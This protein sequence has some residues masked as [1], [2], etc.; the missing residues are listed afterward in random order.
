MNPL[1]WHNCYDQSWKGTL[2]DDAFAHPAKFA[3]ALVERILRHG[4][5]QGYWRVGET[6]GDPFGG[7]ACGGIVAGMLGL[8]WVGVELEPRFVELG[9]KNIAANR[10]FFAG[11]SVEL[12]QGDSR[13]FAEI[14]CGVAGTVCSPPFGDQ[15]PSNNNFV[16]PNDS[17]KRMATDVSTGY[18]NTPGQI[19]ALPAGVV[20]SPPYAAISPEKSSGSIDLRKNYETY[21]ASGGGA[22][23][24]AYCR[25]QKKH[26]QG[27][28]HSPGQIAN[29][30]AA[31][32]SPPYATQVHEGNGIDA[33]KLTGNKAGKNSQAKAEGYGDSPGQLG[34]A[35]GGGETYWQAV[36]TVY[37][38]VHLALPP[39]GILAVVVKDYVKDKQIVPLCDQT[40]ALLVA[41]GFEPLE[42]VHAMLT[43][44]THTNGLFGKETR[45]KERKSFFRRLAEKKGSPRIDWEEVLFVRKPSV[46]SADKETR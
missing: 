2:V 36:E 29:L 34:N 41:C 43:K 42:R 40:L 17:K 7:V 39:G 15:L 32:T 18:G 20:T 21:R 31:V 12:V 37:R 45:T 38:Q 5:A 19:G 22:S 26:S 23:F 35:G 16:A 10:R 11:C 27:Y 6:I 44:T 25:T 24:E 4:L 28:G 1:I 30:S 13:R 33:S 8:N 9:N 46:K 14:V 3:P